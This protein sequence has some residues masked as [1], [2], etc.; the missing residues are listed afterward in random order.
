LG[1]AVACTLVVVGCTA[2][3]A[4]SFSS[5]FFIFSF[6]IIDL[7]STLSRIL[8]SSLSSDTSTLTGCGTGFDAGLLAGFRVP[9]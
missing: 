6:S 9:S 1:G 7:V 8:S 5:F 4:L 3:P 2:L